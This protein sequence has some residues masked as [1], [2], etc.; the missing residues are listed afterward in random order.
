MWVYKK[1]RSANASEMQKR[2]K[3][4]MSMLF[5]TVKTELRTGFIGRKNSSEPHA[6]FTIIFSIFYFTCCLGKDRNTCFFLWVNA[7]IQNYE[8][9]LGYSF[10]IAKL[11]KLNICCLLAE[12]VPVEML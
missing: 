7:F 5:M 8:L 6:Y 4:A 1:E 10:S 12:F 3:H 11:T 9:L 2:N